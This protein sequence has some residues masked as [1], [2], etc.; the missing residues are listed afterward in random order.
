MIRLD[1]SNKPVWLDLGHCVRLHLQPLTT[2][3]MVASRSDPSV[4]ALSEDA[5]D[6]ESALVFAKA[7][8][9]NATLD[10]EG[11]GDSDGNVIQITPEGISALL[12]VWPLFEAFQTGYVAKGL[13]LDQEKNV[14]SL[15]PNG[16]SA[17]ATDTAKPARKPAK[18]ARKS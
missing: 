12:D 15:L 1:L 11:V 5:T 16:S 6:E 14:S 7:L 8:A 4:A 9:C 3:M 10:W 18:T 2:A 17:G 13:V